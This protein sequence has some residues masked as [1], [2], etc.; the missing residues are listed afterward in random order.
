MSALF[1]N[2]KAIRL[3]RKLTQEEMAAKLSVTE[4]TVSDWESGESQPDIDMLI[5]IADTL[6][7]DITTLINGLPDPELRKKDKKHLIVAVGI[8][9]ILSI[10][11]YFLIPL[12]A[13]MRLNFMATEPTVLIQICLLPLFWLVLGWT[14]MQGIGVL[15]VVK[16]VKSK[17]SKA[18]H[19]ACLSIV[20]IY[21]SLMLPFTIETINCFIQSL[22]YQQN[23]ALFPDGFQYSYN[24]PLFWQNIELKVMNFCYNRSAI[25]IIPSMIFW[26]SKPIKQKS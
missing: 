2:I 7:S 3:K 25:F 21:V 15:G 8:L 12:A 9:L 16:R 18:I 14:I 4:Q 6:G 23:P 20:L 24:I 19:I 13:K 26:L 1:E 11:L 10:S 17:S 22:K 5:R